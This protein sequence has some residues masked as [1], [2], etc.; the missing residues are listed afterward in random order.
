MAARF[1]DVG[2]ISMDKLGNGITIDHSTPVQSLSNVQ[3]ISAGEKYSFLIKYDNLWACGANGYGQL[4]DG[5]S[6]DRSTPV[7]ISRINNA[8]S[9]AAGDFHSLMIKKDGTVWAWGSNDNGQL[10][11]GASTDHSAPVNISF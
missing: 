3:S 1:G 9:V 11:D 7:Q 4:G 2:I 8:Q 10:G 5:T 6:T